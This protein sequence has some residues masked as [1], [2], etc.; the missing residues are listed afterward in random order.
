MI[1]LRSIVWCKGQTM[2]LVIE[3]EVDVLENVLEILELEGFEAEG[4]TNGALGVNM[5]RRNPPEL[6]IC[7][8]AMPGYDGFAVLE[9]MRTDSATASIP[10]I[11]LTART[12]R[13]S[14]RHG[15]GLGADDYITKPFTTEELMQAVRARLDRH[16]TIA[17]TARQTLDSAKW[18]LTRMIAHELRTPLVGITSVVNVLSRQRGRLAPDELDDLLESINK[19]SKRLGRVVEQMVFTMQLEMGALTAETLPEEG[20]PVPLRDIRLV[21]INL[22]RRFAF[23]NHDLS[24]RTREE[25]ETDNPLVVCHPSV[26]KHAFAELITNALVYSPPDSFVDIYQWLEDGMVCISIMDN[27]PGIA[28]E[29]QRQ[30]LEAFKQIDRE[31]EEQ[32]G[33]GLGLPLARRLIEAHNGTL[34]LHSA[35]GQGTEVIVRLPVSD[36]ESAPQPDMMDEDAT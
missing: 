12:D 17:K 29:L 13:D 36:V 14:M 10:F 19:G 32:Q 20:L 1:K 6:I 33:M 16:A 21:A 5:A 7:D 23:R 2:I 11:F 35:P 15:M 8:I 9:E 31:S 24:I 34:E 18:Q 3:D 28:P 4:A 22:A 26:L 25:S 30:S 27:G